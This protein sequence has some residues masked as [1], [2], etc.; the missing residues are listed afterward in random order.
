MA[1]G[2]DSADPPVAVEYGNRD[3][4]VGK[5]WYWAPGENTITQDLGGTPLT[6]GQFLQVTYQALSGDT[7]SVADGDVINDRAA[8]EGTTGIYEHLTERTD[9]VDGNVGLTAAQ[10]LLETYKKMPQIVECETLLTG[11]IPGMLVNLDVAKP[12]ILG[13]FLIDSTDGY[14]PAGAPHFRTRLRLLSGSKVG[15]HTPLR[16]WEAFTTRKGAASSASQTVI[17]QGSADTS[18]TGIWT[19]QGKVAF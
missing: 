13:E 3:T 16:V 9:I 8:I 10:Q 6:P 17:S 12:R 5:P 14:L 7:F 11:L 4:D 19:P 1:G 2:N 15:V 18:G